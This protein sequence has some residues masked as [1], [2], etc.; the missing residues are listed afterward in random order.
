[1]RP[2]GAFGFYTDLCDK[3]NAQEQECGADRGQELNAY[4]SCFRGEMPCLAGQGK[5]S[6][7]RFQQVVR[8]RDDGQ[9]QQAEPL[10]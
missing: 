7:P 5:R 8:H 1:M 4:R 2:R 10:R 9:E 6:L 3:R